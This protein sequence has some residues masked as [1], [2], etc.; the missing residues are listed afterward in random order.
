[1]M[2][3]SISPWGWSQIQ[4]RRVLRP[5]SKPYG[6]SKTPEAQYMLELGLTSLQCTVSDS[7][8]LEFSSKL[9]Q[10]MHVI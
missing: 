8:S 7:T 10:A 2:E 9:E 1:M 3:S 4:N 6:K 5:S